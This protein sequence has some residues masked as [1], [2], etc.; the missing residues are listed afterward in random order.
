MRTPRMQQVFAQFTD[1]VAE[2]LEE[3]FRAN[4]GLLVAYVSY[5]HG[6]QSRSVS[7]RGAGGHPA[8]VWFPERAPVDR[9]KQTVFRRAREH[10]R[11]LEAD[12]QRRKEQ[13]IGEAVK[14]AERTERLGQIKKGVLDAMAVAGQ[15]RNEEKAAEKAKEERRLLMPVQ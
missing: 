5:P 1:A 3:E 9:L 12:H 11:Q 2:V 13:A 14:Q 10:V 4:G 15:K 7:P 8:G 6:T